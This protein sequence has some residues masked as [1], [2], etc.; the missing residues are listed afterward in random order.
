MT[1][2]SQLQQA[3]VLFRVLVLL[4]GTAMVTIAGF[5][6]IEPGVL[7]WLPGRSPVI[8]GF[9]GAAV[10]AVAIF[11]RRFCRMVLRQVAPDKVFN[12]FSG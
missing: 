10:L 4:L 11:W 2:N 12:G 3:M 7:R 1:H 6:L 5:A 9:A 8:A